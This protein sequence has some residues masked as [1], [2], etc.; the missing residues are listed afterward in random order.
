M[1]AFIPIDITDARFVSSTI[2]EPDVSEPAWSSGTTYAEFDQVSVISADTHDVYESLQSSNLNHNPATSPTYWILKKKTNRF[3][4]FDWNQGTASVGVSPLTMSVRPGQ[5][6]S[7]VMLEGMKAATAVITV[8]DGIGGPVVLS[9]SEDLLARRATTP[10]EFCFTPFIYDKVFA[11]FDVPPILDPVVTV[12]LTHPSGTCEISR[13]ATGLAYF[14]GNED[15]GSEVDSENYSEI[16]W[17]KYGKA[18]LNPIPS[19]PTM[20]MTLDARP[21]L[22]NRIQQFKELANGRAAVWS[23]MQK[24]NDYEQS[25]VLFGVYQRF[26]MVPANL[27]QAKFDL[28]LKGI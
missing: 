28:T 6:I 9:V 17:D 24:L 5:R 18:T 19:I 12:T 2:A 3:R 8:R 21:I 23:A 22:I 16:A 1:K 27:N 20:R 10:Y 11:T 14:L 4:M 25:H 13:F 26:S 7:A 15:W